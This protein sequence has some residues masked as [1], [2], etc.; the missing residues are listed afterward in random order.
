MYK[1]YVLVRKD[2]GLSHIAV[3]A[4]HALAEWIKQYPLSS[5]LEWNNTLVYLGVADELELNQWHTLLSSMEPKTKDWKESYW[6][7]S[8]TAF[9]VL[10]TPEVQKLVKGL[11]LI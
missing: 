6:D 9:A 5:E 3:Q 1:L 2:L 8:F 11:K 10:G 4:G 7:N